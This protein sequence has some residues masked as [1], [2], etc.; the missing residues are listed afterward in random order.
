[1]IHENQGDKYPENYT[2]NL[3]VG[4]LIGGLV[5]ALAMLLLAPQSGKDTRRKIQERSIE[6]RDRTT[7]MVDDTMAK[8]RT[9]ANKITMGLKDQVQEVA[10]DG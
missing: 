6:L 3:L 9:N 7:E 10:V 8:V 5:G 1:M 4:M 2:Q